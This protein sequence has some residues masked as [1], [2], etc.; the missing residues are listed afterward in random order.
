MGRRRHW[1][2]AVAQGGFDM[3]ARAALDQALSDLRA[4]RDAVEAGEAVAVSMELLPLESLT[5]ASTF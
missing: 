2:A 4:A 1:A 5:R 3:A